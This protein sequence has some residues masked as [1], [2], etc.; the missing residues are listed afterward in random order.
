MGK[1][2]TTISLD[3]DTYLKARELRFNISRVCN[4]ALKVNIKHRQQQ[5]QNQA[6]Q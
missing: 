6:R 4:Q 2:I 1:V 3:I 5:V